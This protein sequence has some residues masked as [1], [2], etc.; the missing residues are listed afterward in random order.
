MLIDVK[1]SLA[2]RAALRRGDR[3]SV[4]PSRIGEKVNET[5]GERLGDSHASHV[6]LPYCTKTMP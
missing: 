5:S 6:K 1:Q 2:I 3:M 4:P